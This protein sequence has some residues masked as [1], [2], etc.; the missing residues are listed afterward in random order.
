MTTPTATEIAAEVRRGS[1]KPREAVQ[2]ALDRIAER[3]EPLGAFQVV[4]ADRALAEADEVAMRADL[5]DLPLAGVPIA[6]KDNVAV[7]GEPMR[8]GTAA[9]P[10]DPSTRDHEVVR[11][12]RA[13]GAVVVGITRMPELG[14][15]GATDSVFGVTRNPWDRSRTPGGSSGGAAAAVASGMVPVAHGNDGMGSIRG[16][17]AC[18]GLVG[19]KPGLGTV[20]ADVGP[21]DWHGMT[22]N[23]P[24]ATTVG[25]AALVLSVMAARP[26][27]AEVREPA[28]PVRVA[29]AMAPPIAISRLDAEHRRGVEEVAAA[30]RSAGHV[31]DE[32]RLPVPTSAALAALERWFSGAQQEVE[33]V[34]AAQLERRVRVHAAIGRRVGRF[35]EDGQRDA[36][37]ATVQRAVFDRY[38]VVLTPTLAAPP[39]A[40]V[41]WGERGWLANVVADSRYAPYPAPWNLLGYPAAAVPAGIHRRTGT[42]LSAHLGGPLGSEPLL[43]S[44]AAQLEQ[45]LPWPRLAPGY[46]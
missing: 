2:E 46:T 1:R 15:F 13:A 23:G 28:G 3:D 43:L 24:L 16:P 19:V 7:A 30:L 33:H 27:L 22:E 9:T 40:A 29:L 31:V 39:I 32:V 38:D 45:A 11:R 6:V 20:P 36:I 34:D 35:V 25:D 41:R 37:R 5:A 44:L 42:P 8:S 14:V 21:T 17:A 26:E 12:L 10:R 18:C 4:R